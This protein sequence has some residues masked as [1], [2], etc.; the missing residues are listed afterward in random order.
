MNCG[1]GRRRGSD[2]TLLWLW[3][4]PVATAPIGTLAWEPPYATGVALKSK[5]IIIILK[6]NKNIHKRLETTNILQ[7][8][9]T[10][11]KGNLGA[12]STSVEVTWLVA[13]WSLGPEPWLEP[14]KGS[15]LP[16]ILCL[17]AHRVRTPSALPV[18]PPALTRLPSCVLD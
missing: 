11:H 17:D 2:P 13:R 14:M 8:F 3:H 12:P 5:I 1:V 6:Q 4:R 18:P 9:L 15:G 16:T 10:L 7:I